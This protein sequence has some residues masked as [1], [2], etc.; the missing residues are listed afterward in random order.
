MLSDP[1]TYTGATPNAVRFSLDARTESPRWCSRQGLPHH[2]ASGRRGRAHPQ[3]GTWTLAPPTR[4][5]GRWRSISIPRPSRP[6]APPARV[7][8]RGA[9]HAQRAEQPAAVQLDN[10]RLSV[11]LAG[12]GHGH[13]ADTPTTPT[14]PK[15]PTTPGN[16]GTTNN[17]GAG[18]LGAAPRRS[19]R[20]GRPRCPAP[21]TRSVS[22]GSSWSST[23]ASARPACAG[24]TRC[25]TACRRVSPPPT[26]RRA[27][28]APTASRRPSLG[29]RG[30]AARGAVTG[31]QGPRAT[32][33]RTPRRQLGGHHPEPPAA[34]H[35]PAHLGRRRAARQRDHRPH[36]GGPQRRRLPHRWIDAVTLDS[37]GR[38]TFSVPL[39]RR[40]LS[41]AF[42][43][44]DITRKKPENTRV[45][46]S[47]ASSWSQPAHLGRRGAPHQRHPGAVR[48]R[49]DRRGHRPRRTVAVEPAPAV[50]RGAR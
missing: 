50:Q 2:R 46:A 23:S 19:P 32:P 27:A 9:G 16:G 42:V 25:S 29:D 39:R 28:S 14:T 6:T 41:T 43:P 1:F 36:E 33:T 20:R 26:S 8:D 45:C 5:G 17:N 44:L 22:R 30:Q 11:R 21:P 48:R 40:P 13:H 35:Q 12:R 34:H 49:P 38:S 10:I 24:S 3:L 47:A 31:V 7:R 4:R 37:S 15:P 18:G